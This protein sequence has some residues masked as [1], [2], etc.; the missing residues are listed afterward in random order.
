MPTKTIRKPRGRPKDA[1]L[2]DRRRDQIL[3]AA[4]QIFAA[5]GY[6]N[7]DTQLLAD[8][9][10]TGKGTIYR[11]FPSK[12]ALFLA[13][14]DR[15]MRDLRAHV[16]GAVEDIADPLRRVAGAVRAYLEYF[17]KNPQV[18]ELLILERAVFKDRQK[19]TYFVH[20]ERNIGPWIEL[21]QGLIDAGR[22]RAMPIDRI[23]DVLSGVLYGTMFI[24][25]FVRGNKSFEA[26]AD[27][28]VDLFFR[29]LLTDSERDRGGPWLVTKGG[30]K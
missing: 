27:Q 25:F 12:E 30:E 6:A 15:G 9:L 1:D 26:Q 4:T 2:A 17:D 16:D 13:A 3:R 18:V 7:A 11:Y 21:F 23:T 22:V 28:I 8:Q 10:G 14:V 29:G 20:R 24:N 5:D 19:P